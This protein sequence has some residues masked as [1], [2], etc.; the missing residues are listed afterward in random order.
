VVAVS[1]VVPE[2]RRPGAGNLATTTQASAVTLVAAES[3]THQMTEAA[4]VRAPTAAPRADRGLRV[5]LLASTTDGERRRV[6]R[7]A[8]DYYL[9]CFQEQTGRAVVTD[10][11]AGL[12]LAGGLLAELVLG[13]HL[14][15]HDNLLY[16]AAG[17][18]PPSD[19]ALWEVLH[20]VAGQRRPQGVGTW[21]RFLATDAVTDVRHRMCTAGL[22]ARVRTRRLGVTAKDRYLPTDSNAAAWQAIRLANQLCARDP[23]PLPDAV[24]AG[25]VNACGLLKHVLWA[26]EHAAGFGHA[27]HLRHQL[28]APLVAVVA[29]TEAA[30]GQHVLTRR[31]M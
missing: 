20:A 13:G 28:P 8:D 14:L 10:A 15:V 11:V 7:L 31:R 25:L 17:V 5:C 6:S 27:D 1:Q 2:P 9:I 18:A 4:P 21:L 19:L 24:L 26:P 3:T 22:L 29:H 23:M 30:V 12:G 16:P